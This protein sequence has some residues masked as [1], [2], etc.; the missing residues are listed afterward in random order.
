MKGETVAWDIRASSEELA[1]LMEAGFVYR[2]CRNFREARDVFEGVRALRPESEVPEI[3]LG[4]VSFEAGD[5]EDAI[6]HYQR[7]IKIN[8]RSAYA[9]A[10]LGEAQLFRNDAANAYVSLQRA[11]ELDPEG[12]FGHLAR[13][14]LAFLDEL[15]DTVSAENRP[16][17]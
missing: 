13:S 15:R 3:A 2:Y 11:L 4:T 9:Y 16:R 17:P 14:L 7:A 6:R 8:A 10:H 12:E 1:L 5:F